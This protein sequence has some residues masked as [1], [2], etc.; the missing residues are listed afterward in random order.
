MKLDPKIVEAA[1]NFPSD[2][3]GEERARDV[4]RAASENVPDE[5]V[6]AAIEASCGEDDYVSAVR[7]IL[8]AGLAKWAEE[9]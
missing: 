2:P 6:D 8:S 4:L 1:K 9:E 5:V 7:K 3:E